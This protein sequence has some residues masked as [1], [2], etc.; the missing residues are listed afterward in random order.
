MLGFPKCLFDAHMSG[1]A[2]ALWSF[3]VVAVLSLSCASVPNG[4][5]VS[6]SIVLLINGRFCRRKPIDLEAIEARETLH[7]QRKCP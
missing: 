5:L 4:V 1:S 2:V 3:I 7:A 6:F